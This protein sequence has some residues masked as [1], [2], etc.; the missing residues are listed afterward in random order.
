MRG[1]TAMRAGT[2]GRAAS[3][4]R[5]FAVRRASR[6]AL[7]AAAA[8]AKKLSTAAVDEGKFSAEDAAIVMGAGGA[9]SVDSAASL[10]SS[11]VSASGATGAMWAAAVQQVKAELG[12]QDAGGADAAAAKPR[13]GTVVDAAMMDRALSMV[14]PLSS[15]ATGADWAAAAERCLAQTEVKVLSSKDDSKVE[16][17]EDAA[18]VALAATTGAGAEFSAD[19]F[20]SALAVVR[21]AFPNLDE[22]EIKMCTDDLKSDLSLSAAREAEATAAEGGAGADVAKEAVA[23]M[24]TSV[25]GSIAAPADEEGPEPTFSASEWSSDLME[26]LEEVVSASDGG[27]EDSSASAGLSVGEILMPFSPYTE[28]INARLAMIGFALGAATEMGPSE[29][30]FAQQFSGE[31]QL[32]VFAW[33]LGV[34]LLT[35]LNATMDKRITGIDGTPFNAAHELALGR[36]AMLGFVGT[37]IVEGKF[38][39]PFF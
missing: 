11:A 17:V 4:S 35:V 20:E 32:A 6:G 19:A 30:T 31:G 23:G 28:R 14:R 22:E 3:L 13:V 29:L 10:A 15:R 39:Q 34:V 26:A 18:K 7:A 8:A 24:I 1:R 25:I 37:L 33:V 5:G 9:A 27:E 38:G 36:I 21:E 12:G 2:S 16:L